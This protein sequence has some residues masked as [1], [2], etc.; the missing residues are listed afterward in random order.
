MDLSGGKPLSQGRPRSGGVWVLVRGAHGLRSKAWERQRECDDV[1]ASPA[2]PP[3]P[4]I[5]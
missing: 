4:A 5:P 1:T 2:N 3:R